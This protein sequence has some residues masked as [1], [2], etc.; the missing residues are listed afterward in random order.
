M[1]PKNTL[2]EELKEQGKSLVAIKTEMRSIKENLALHMK[3]TDQNELMIRD[4]QKYK[5]IAVGAIS[6]V[7]FLTTIALK[8][9]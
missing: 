9:L 2:A 6:I 1:A 3:R 7:S 8:F 5:W 4:L